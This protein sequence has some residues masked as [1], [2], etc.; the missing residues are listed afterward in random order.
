MD[1][2]IVGLMKNEGR[3]G[4]YQHQGNLYPEESP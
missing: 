4:G 3:I 1:M 2:D